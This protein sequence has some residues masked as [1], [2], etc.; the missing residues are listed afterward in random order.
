MFFNVVV[1]AAIFGPDATVDLLSSWLK[2]LTFA[3]GVIE[4]LNIIAI[5]AI[6]LLLKED[7]CAIKCYNKCFYYIN[8]MYG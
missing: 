4:P 2:S 6:P 5:S 1:Y 3:M 8:E 7:G